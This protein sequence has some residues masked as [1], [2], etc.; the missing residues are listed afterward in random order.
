M[1]LCPA[2]S[3]PIT[4]MRSGYQLGATCSFTETTYTNC[5]LIQNLERDASM[6]KVTGLLAMIRLVR[7][8]LMLCTL[9]EI[10]SDR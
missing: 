10:V 3:G 1:I 6:H 7:L 5:L 2:Y 4:D 8:L 9:N